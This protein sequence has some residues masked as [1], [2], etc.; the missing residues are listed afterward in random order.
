VK[1][2]PIDAVIVS[3]ARIRDTYETLPRTFSVK[4]PSDSM[5]ERLVTDPSTVIEV[6][7]SVATV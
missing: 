5:N 2:P 3:V 6:L 4:A 7:D 1:L